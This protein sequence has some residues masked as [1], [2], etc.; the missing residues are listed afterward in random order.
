[1][2]AA[3]T[4][5]RSITI[6]AS[7]SLFVA[8]S[9]QWIGRPPAPI[10]PE[11]ASSDARP[12][13]NTFL[14]FTEWYL[15]FSPRELASNEGPPSSLPF[16][17]HVRE[18]WRGYWHSVRAIPEGTPI[19]WGYHLMIMVIGVSTTAEYSVRGVYERT[20]GRLTE[21]ISGADTC[22]DREAR[23]TAS[24]YAR[25]LDQ[26]PWYQFN[27]WAALERTWTDCSITG[28]ARPLRS[29]E[30]RYALSSEYVFKGVYA[31]LIGGGTH[32]AYEPALPT[33]LVRARRLGDEC[34][35]SDGCEMDVRLTRYQAFVDEARALSR[36]SDFVQIAGNRGPILIS[37]LVRGSPSYPA[38][39]R[40]LFEQTS[41]RGLERHVL[42]VEVT[43]LA[44][45]LR[46]TE[47]HRASVQLE[48]I[49]DY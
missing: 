10:Q 13:D 16:F 1:M 14:T 30:R 9:S 23:R 11:P 35:E 15:V 17:E 5:Y 12:L 19:N 44:E 24:A 4:Q 42:V 40:I 21:L 49:Y 41:L 7:L 39:S 32:A 45:L 2:K 43:H 37:T 47:E 38:F 34:R 48:H 28:S 31:W 3:L 46:W 8:I 6:L 33:T 27:F 26:E 29:L 25:F 18:V 20:I 36:T 22:E